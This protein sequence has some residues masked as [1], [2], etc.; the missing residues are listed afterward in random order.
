M[1]ASGWLEELL[2]LMGFGILK[3]EELQEDKLGNRWL[4]IDSTYLTREQISTLI[5]ENGSGLD[6]LQ[7][8]TNLVF[9]QGY[10]Y[11]VELDGFRERQLGALQDIAVKAVEHVRQ[12][13]GS[14]VISR[15][16]PGERRY[17]HLLLKEYKEVET[18]SEGEEPNRQL[19]VRW[20]EDESA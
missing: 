14:Y 9:N 3:V 5:G 4:V 13:Q 18:F 7:Y 8:M 17:I 20:L 15:L 19:V 16:S 12:N 10:T 6:A 1:A 11:I 2:N